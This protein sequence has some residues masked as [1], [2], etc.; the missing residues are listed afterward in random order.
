MCVSASTRLCNYKACVCVG[1]R[2]EGWRGEDGVRKRGRERGR[3]GENGRREME[4]E[5]NRGRRAELAKRERGRGQKIGG[6]G[7]HEMAG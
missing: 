5:S 6:E 7:D 1:E 4:R 2:G 3:K